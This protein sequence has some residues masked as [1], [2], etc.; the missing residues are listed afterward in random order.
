V[1]ELIAQC[2]AHP[3]YEYPETERLRKPAFPGDT[4]MLVK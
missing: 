1:V 2:D 4:K 3:Q